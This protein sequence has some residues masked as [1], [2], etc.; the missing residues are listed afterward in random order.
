MLEGI[1]TSLTYALQVD[2]ST[3]IDNKELL[4]VYVRYLYQENVHEDLLCALYLPTN[5]T[6]PK[7]FKSSDGYRSRPGQIKLFFCAGICT[8]GAAAMTGRLSGLISRIKEVA[9]ESKSTHSVMHKKMLASQK[10]T[11]EFNIVLI[12]DVKVI[13]HIKEHA[14][15]SRLFEQLC[16]K[17]NAEHRRLLLYTE[18]RWLS[19]V[20]SLTRVFKLRKPLQRFF[21]EKK[22]P[23]AAHFNDKKWV[24]KLANLCDIF[25]LLNE[26]NLSL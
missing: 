7:L 13:N 23:L 24:A 1:S 12:D 2:E 25:R 20:K 18:I 22:S 16:E 15:N 5:K 11:P 6:G 19:Q 17:M 9:P 3:D 14:L 4:L 21:S 8:D 26:F 10:M